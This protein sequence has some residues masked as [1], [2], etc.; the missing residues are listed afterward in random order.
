MAYG[1][2]FLFKKNVGRLTGYLGYTYSKI[3]RKYPGINKGQEYI[4]EYDRPHN[5][6]LCLSYQINDKLTL[7]AVWIYQT[8]LPYT[9]AI[10][11]QY[12]PDLNKRDGKYP[13]YY[14]ALIYG[15]RNSKRMRDYHRL[16]IALIYNRLTKKRKLNS[17]WTFSV[18]NVYNRQNP[19][20]YYYNVTGTGEVYYPGPRYDYW[21][22]KLYQVSF[23]PILPSVSYKVYFDNTSFQR[24]KPKTSIKQKINNWLYYEN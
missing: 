13:F 15:E 18:Y 4:F 2:E 14:E 9:P 8:G 12:T 1:V 6:S 17:T 21:K 19:Y 11:R 10:G 16:D 7:S 22:V 23:F 20:Y 5:G 3:T 24:T